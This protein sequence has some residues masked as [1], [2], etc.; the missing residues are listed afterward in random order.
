MTSTQQ[1]TYPGSI[2]YIPAVMVACVVECYGGRCNEMLS[3][4]GTTSTS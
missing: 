4:A 3:D 1:T 2:E